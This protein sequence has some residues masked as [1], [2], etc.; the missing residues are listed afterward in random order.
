[1]KDRMCA[2]IVARV[3]IAKA[4]FGCISEAPISESSERSE[5]EF[6]FTIF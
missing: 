1:M 4:I 2:N 3:S 6:S 5:L